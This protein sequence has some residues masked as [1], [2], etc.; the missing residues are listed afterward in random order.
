MWLRWWGQSSS[1]RD[2]ECKSES[3][4]KLGGLEAR[5]VLPGSA[6]LSVCY[7]PKPMTTQHIRTALTHT[8]TQHSAS[9][10]LVFW[11]MSHRAPGLLQEGKGHPKE[12]FSQGKVSH[13][14]LSHR[15]LSYRRL[16]QR[17]LPHRR[18]GRGRLSRR[19]LSQSQG[20]QSRL[21]GLP[22]ARRWDVAKS[23][24]LLSFSARNRLPVANIGPNNHE[25]LNALVFLFGNE[26]GRDPDR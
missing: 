19:K 11:W 14:G 18:L 24:R 25:T 17:R 3:F 1:C 6:M 23:Q 5:L 26:L 7:K 21:A 20:R 4:W 12:R 15:R 10:R 2:P 16:F 9:R 8:N 22:G 13:R